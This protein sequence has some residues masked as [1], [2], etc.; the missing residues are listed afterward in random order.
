MQ[1][2]STLVSVRRA[3]RGV[4]GGLCYLCRGIYARNRQTILLNI[5]AI[6]VV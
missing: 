4:E 2:D 5:N 3:F 1:R 6:S